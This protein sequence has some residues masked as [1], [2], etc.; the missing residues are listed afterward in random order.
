LIITEEQ[1]MKA[2]VVHEFKEPIHI[3]DVETPR[4]GPDEVLIRTEACGVC[5]SDLHLA[6]G[7]WP[8]LRFVKKPLIL[9]H[10]VV[11]R[12]VEKGDAVD[13]LQIGDRVGVAWTHWTCG[14][15]DYCKEG[16]EN[17]CKKQTITG[18]SVDGGY[19][20][21]MKAKA[22][23]ALKVP[24]N[25]SSDEA[26][27]LFCAGVTVYHAIK[28]SG[29]KPGHRVAIFGIGGLGHLAVQIAKTF[30]PEVI[31]VDIAD[32]KLE[33]AQRLGADRTINAMK[34]DVVKT[35]RQMG[36]VHIAIIT[37]AAKA[38]FDA[39]FYGLRSNGKMMVV[40]MPADTLTFPAIQM[41]EVNIAASATGTRQDIREVLELASAGKIRCLV[42]T[43]SV[44]KINEIFDRMKAGQITGRVVLTF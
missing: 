33:L 17:L 4:P 1:L 44:E 32:D 21:L 13:H 9:G 31:A 15:C 40:G 25:L 16:E 19:A 5:H 24:E 26:A 34:E 41:R 8:Q 6:E 38:A 28:K 37:S 35:L 12:V 18:A 11:G 42:E 20:E 10:E 7:D 27:P 36:G 22:S 23:H 3:E 30:G 2:A 29:M 43:E 39:A 14:E